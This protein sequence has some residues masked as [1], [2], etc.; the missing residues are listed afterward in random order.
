MTTP[1]SRPI[2]GFRFV[3]VRLGDTLQAIAARELGDAGR[4]YDLIAYNQLVPPFITDDPVLVRDGV[5]TAGDL[6][7][8]PAPSL[9]ESGSADPENVFQRDIDLTG[10]VLS[11]E[12][13][14]F[15]VVS[16]RANLRQ[17]IKHRVETERGELIFQLGRASWRERVCQ[18]VSSSVVAVQLKKKKH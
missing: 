5:R 10:G 9:P 16:G 14:D 1:F 11:V 12:N 8:V 7:L 17:A 3:E 2:Y 6:I 13:G 4:W 18:Y 15:A